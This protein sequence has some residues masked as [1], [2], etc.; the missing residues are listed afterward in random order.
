MK[1]GTP[2]KDRLD[3]AS[4]LIPCKSKLLVAIEEDF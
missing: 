1:N 2:M 4:N 3:G